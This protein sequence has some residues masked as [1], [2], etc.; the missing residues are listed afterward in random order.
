VSIFPLPKVS[1]VA[2]LPLTQTV[3]QRVAVRE[4]EQ[5]MGL[6]STKPLCPY[7]GSNLEETNYAPPL[8]T[9]RCRNCIRKNELERRIEALEAAQQN[10]QADTHDDDGLHR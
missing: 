2:P 7:C 5:T 3:R 9:H 4:R 1:G 8:P 10:G 6:F